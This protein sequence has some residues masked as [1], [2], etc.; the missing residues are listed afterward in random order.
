MNKQMSTVLETVTHILETREEWSNQKTRGRN[1]LGGP[2]VK[3][4]P[5]HGKKDLDANL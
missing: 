2:K 1:D 5:F 4:I 3:I